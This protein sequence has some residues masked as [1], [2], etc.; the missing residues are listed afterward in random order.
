M[1]VF[2]NDKDGQVRAAH[3]ILGYDPLQK[4]FADAKH[5]ISTNHPRLLKITVVEQGFLISEGSPIPEGIPLV[6]SSS[7]HQAAEDEGH[8]GPS[9]KGF[10]AYDQA[11]PS[12][13]PS[14]NLGDP[15]LSE[16]ELLLVETTSRAEM[17]LKRKPPTSLFDLIEGQPGKGAQGKPQSNAPTPPPQPQPIQT[18]SSSIKSQP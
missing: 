1:A 11:D 8:L 14:G 10:G 2:V 16:A 12:E 18:R 4:S 9:E 15:N 7:S 5:V 3:K 6:D 13:D 17:G